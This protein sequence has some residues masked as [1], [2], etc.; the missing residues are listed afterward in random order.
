MKKT[1]PAEKT[2]KSGHE[3]ENSGMDSELHELFLDELADLLSAEQQLVKALPKIAKAAQAE[4]L[5]E[6]IT[7]HLSET[8]EHV[9]RL[10]DVF[11]LLGETPR[12]KKCKAMAGLLEE[13]AELI[14]EK[15]SSPA[16]DAAIIAAAQ[17]V[18]HYEIASY[19][20]V[21]AWARRMQ[22]TQEEV[23]LLETLNEEKAADEKLTGIAE[24]AA[25][26]KAEAGH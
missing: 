11:H 26:Q 9:K 15:K 17:K 7:S 10:Q 2:A 24:R 5:A 8:E 6:A 20:T 19:G 12:S 25:N 21:C 23:L 13:G 4:E 16:L 1:S 14:K 22:H 18:E 3:A